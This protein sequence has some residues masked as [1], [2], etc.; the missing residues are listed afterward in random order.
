MSESRRIVIR[1]L[2]APLLLALFIVEPAVANVPV[3]EASVTVRYYDL[4]LDNPKDIANLY[5]RIRGAAVQVCMPEEGPQVVNRVFWTA[6]NDCFFQAID[7][8]VR[9]VHSDKLNVYHSERTHGS[10]RRWV[11][12]P[13]TPARQR[14]G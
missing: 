3:V 4:N 9:T 10:K 13:A 12:S 6:W 7:N 5:H 8:A 1:I 2:A 14:P 11:E